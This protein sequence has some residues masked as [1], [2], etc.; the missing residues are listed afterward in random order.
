MKYF[1]LFI[2]IFSQLSANPKNSWQDFNDGQLFIE[3]QLQKQVNKNKAKNVIV[4]I[5]DG[6]GITTNYI[7]RL[8]QG[9]KK[10]RAW[11]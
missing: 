6:Y 5:G 10:W 8:N 1:F 7:N 9:Q 11:R 3:N 2:I 4:I